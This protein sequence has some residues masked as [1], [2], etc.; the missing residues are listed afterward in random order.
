[1]GISGPAPGAPPRACTAWLDE[2]FTTAGNSF[3]A[4]SA[5]LSGVGRASACWTGT[6]P[7]NGKASVMAEANKTTRADERIRRMVSIPRNVPDMARHSIAG[8]YG[9]VGAGGV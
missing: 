3:A 7:A 4:R 6:A 2:M 8:N 1:M 5:K 9:A